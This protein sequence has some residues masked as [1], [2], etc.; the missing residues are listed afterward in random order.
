VAAALRT[1]EQN[2]SAVCAG[3]KVRLRD[4]RLFDVTFALV[5]TPRE[6]LA[7]FLANPGDNSR[8][9]GLHRIENLRSAIRG[10]VSQYLATDWLWLAAI[11]ISGDML[12]IPEVLMTRACGAKY[13]HYAGLSKWNWFPF[14]MFSARLLRHKEAW[15]MG[16]LL[17]LFKLNLGGH[18]Y[19][20]E[21]RGWRNYSKVYAAILKV[22]RA[23]R[24]LTTSIRHCN[25]AWSHDS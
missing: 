12:E 17:Y 5:G 8:F 1:L 11:A 22:N 14:V 23:M 16:T 19:V 25:R 4:H 6:R 13:K 18:F 3:P 2:P 24:R 15:S 10:K 9:Y 21:M 20:A 7:A